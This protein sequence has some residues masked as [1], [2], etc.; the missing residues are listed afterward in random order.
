MRQSSVG[1]LHCHT[2][3]SRTVLRLNNCRLVV[4]VLQLRCTDT[5]THARTFSIDIPIYISDGHIDAKQYN[6]ICKQKQKNKL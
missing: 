1:V 6:P 2:S 4:I 5:H 3:K